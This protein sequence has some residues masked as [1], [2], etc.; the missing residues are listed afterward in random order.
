MRAALADD[1]IAQFVAAM[2]VPHRAE[3]ESVLAKIAHFRIPDR[4]GEQIP[5]RID[6]AR[7]R[8]G[9]AR[10]GRLMC[11]VVLADKRLVPI[12]EKPDRMQRGAERATMIVDRVQDL[13]VALFYGIPEI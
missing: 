9:R 10:Q 12:F 13:G 1:I 8:K 2:A 3:I 7:G 5:V 6:K 11:L 4:A